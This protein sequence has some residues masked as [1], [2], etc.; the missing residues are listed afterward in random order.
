[1]TAQRRQT[2]CIIINAGGYKIELAVTVA[3]STF[4]R[5]HWSRQCHKTLAVCFSHD[6]SSIFAWRFQDLF[7]NRSII[8]SNEQMYVNEI[9][10]RVQCQQMHNLLAFFTAALCIKVTFFTT[11]TGSSCAFV[12]LCMC[13]CVLQLVYSVKFPSGQSARTMV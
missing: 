9:Y 5:C 6:W 4:H 12:P 11:Y 1:M 13:I 10:K 3:S 2:L 8:P 7:G